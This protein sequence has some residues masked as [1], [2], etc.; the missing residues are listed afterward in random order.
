[1]PIWNLVSEYQPILHSR[2][3][4]EVGSSLER[5]AKMTIIISDPKNFEKL[6]PLFKA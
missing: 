3:F 6:N 2:E 1:M 4:Q 5:V